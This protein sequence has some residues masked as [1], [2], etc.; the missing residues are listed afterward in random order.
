MI[1][2][3]IELSNPRNPELRPLIVR[4]LVDTGAHDDRAKG[5]FHTRLIYAAPS[6]SS[7]SGYEYFGA[8]VYLAKGPKARPIPAWGEAPGPRD[9]FLCKG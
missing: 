3:E 9:V 2:A 4:A 5:R 6:G 1:H 8:M 7:R